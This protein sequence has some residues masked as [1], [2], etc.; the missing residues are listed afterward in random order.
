MALKLNF[1]KVIVK[2]PTDRIKLAESQILQQ[3]N[4]ISLRVRQEDYNGNEI[5]SLI[6]QTATTIKLKAEKIALEGLVTANENFKILLDGSIEAVNAKLSGAI[7]ATKMVAT[8]GDDYYGEIG[9]TSGLVGFGLFD[10]R[11][12]TEAF[13]EVIETTNGNGFLIRDKN[14]RTRYEATQDVTR[15]TSPN[16]NIR[17][18]ITDTY[19]NII[20]NG[21]VIGNWG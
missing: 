19:V 13:F 6:N 11:Y 18:N 16:G 1:S 9:V 21:A 12:S 17:V 7:T 15:M 2:D 20:K 10:K 14:N 3:A 8:A 5:A 4:E